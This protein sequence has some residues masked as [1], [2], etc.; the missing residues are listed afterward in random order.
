MRVSHGCIRLYP[1]DIEKLYS[2][3]NIGTSV[4][5][6]D[7][8]VK[9][10][11]SDG[12]LYLEVHQP[13]IEDGEPEF[14]EPTLDDVVMA[15]APFRKYG[16]DIDADQVDAALRLGDGIPVA[17]AHRFTQEGEP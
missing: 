12:T 2:M 10:G 1:E 9:A 4:T 7:Q 5:I 8:P 15:I 14:D 11:W 17:I 6:I 16:I 3:T 13:L